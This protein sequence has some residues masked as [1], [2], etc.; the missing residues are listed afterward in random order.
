MFSW[1][2]ISVARDM[3]MLYYERWKIYMW[4]IREKPSS[5][6]VQGGGSTEN[7]YWAV[8]IIA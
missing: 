8:T 5:A 4:W 2:K 1:F 6:R 3:N 7:Q